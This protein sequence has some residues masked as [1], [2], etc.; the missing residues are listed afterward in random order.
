[1][2]RYYYWQ[3]RYSVEDYSRTIDIKFL[4]K[5]WYL[6]KWVSFKSWW[7]YWKRNWEDN[8][9]I[10]VEVNKW[11][12]TWYIRVYFTQTKEDWT[13]KEF[14]YQIPLVSTVCNY[15]GI[16]R[17]FLCPCKWNRCSKLYF[18]TNWIFASRKTL[19]LCYD[20][21]KKSKKRRYFWYMMWEA[22]TRILVIKK[23]MKYPY[24]NW[25]PTRKM[26]RI[27][28]LRRRAPSKEEIESFEW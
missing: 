6:D 3:G 22:Y 13:K 25:K 10:S 8:W 7:L 12:N 24:R 26:R 14:D 23:D 15:W 9:T 21:Q 19:N 1:M 27:L 16:R 18:Q 5:Y 11:D 2:W 20:E 28:N 17:W 4:K